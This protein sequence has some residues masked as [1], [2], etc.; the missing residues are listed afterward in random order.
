MSAYW[1]ISPIY[2][3]FGRDLGH[4][5]ATLKD[6]S[7]YSSSSVLQWSMAIPRCVNKRGYFLSFTV[8]GRRLLVAAEYWCLTLYCILTR[9]CTYHM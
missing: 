5:A 7:D 4:L 1:F 2:A 3:I 9:L 8:M 6:C